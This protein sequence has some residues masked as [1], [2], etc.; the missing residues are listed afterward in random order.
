MLPASA[1]SGAGG[2]TRTLQRLQCSQAWAWYETGFG[3]RLVFPEDVPVAPWQIIENGSTLVPLAAI[4]TK[5]IRTACSA[6]A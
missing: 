4:S 5:P 6:T 2:R 3:R 1:I